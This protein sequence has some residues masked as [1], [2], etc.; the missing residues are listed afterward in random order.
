MTTE[1]HEELPLIAPMAVPPV[2]GYY[3]IDT[4]GRHDQLKPTYLPTPEE[5]ARV[6]EE[7]RDEVVSQM[8]NPHH[9]KYDPAVDRKREPN[10]REYPAFH[11]PRR[12]CLIED[13]HSELMDSEYWNQQ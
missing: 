7:L 11:A 8:R 1:G 13:E 2:S 10:I 9:V 4:Q 12:R 6:T 5:I 3:R